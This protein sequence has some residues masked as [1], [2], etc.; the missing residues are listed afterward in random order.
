MPKPEE[1]EYFDD[2]GHG[3]LKVNNTHMA[4]VLEKKINWKNLGRDSYIKWLLRWA[5]KVMGIW[6]GKRLAGCSDD[7]KK[8]PPTNP[9]IEKK[10]KT[11]QS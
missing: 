3:S 10:D 6:N 8:W 2:I 4:A 5:L 11:K 1:G 7:Y 9:K